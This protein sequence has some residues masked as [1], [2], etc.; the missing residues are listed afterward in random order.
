[1][2]IWVVD[3]GRVRFKRLRANGT[4]R[5]A[6]NLGKWKPTVRDYEARRTQ[7]P[8]KS[9]GWKEPFSNFCPTPLRSCERDT[10]MWSFPWKFTGKGGYEIHKLAILRDTCSRNGWFCYYRARKERKDLLRCLFFGCTVERE[11][12][13]IL[14]S[15]SSSN[16]RNEQRRNSHCKTTVIERVPPGN[17]LSKRPKDR[18][19]KE[20]PWTLSFC[21]YFS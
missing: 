7:R 14:V 16:K 1:M 11:T 4:T 6:S 15:W 8:W 21:G 3:K 17:Y 19:K 12:E 5:W 20:S 13:V 18:G 2:K 10:G 9:R